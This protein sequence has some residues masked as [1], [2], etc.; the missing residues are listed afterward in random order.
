MSFIHRFAAGLLVAG[1]GAGLATP[2][3]AS[4]LRWTVPET[5]S[6]SDVVDEVVA[7][8]ELSGAAAERVLRA[9]GA[10]AG[11]LLAEQGVLY[12]WDT[13]VP[14]YGESDYD[15]DGDGFADDAAFGT[16]S[17]GG[18]GVD[19][20]GCP[21]APEIVFSPGRAFNNQLNPLAK[22]SEWLS[23]PSLDIAFPPASLGE[24]T[25]VFGFFQDGDADADGIST[26]DRVA[27]GHLHREGIVHR[28]IAARGTVSGVVVRDGRRGLRLAD[29]TVGDGQPVGLVLEGPTPALV[30]PGMTV[31]LDIPPLPVRCGERTPGPGDAAMIKGIAAGARMDAQTA[32]RAYDALLATIVEVVNAGG[33][34]DLGE[35]GLFAAETTITATVT[36]PCAGDPDNCPPPETPLL[37]ADIWE[38]RVSVSGESAAEIDSISRTV[39]ALAERAAER[40]PDAP[41][42]KEVKTEAK[43]K[44]K[45]KAGAELSG[46]VN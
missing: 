10:T 28:D 1:I 16:L 19:S 31:T 44:V 18:T 36:N 9:F 3:M 41:A 29:S 45:F 22:E 26:G 39:K 21:L 32:T 35:V 20:N 25:L 12:L 13:D 8:T 14:A 42:R 7:R 38:M 4:P 5:L 34:A 15:S 11:A 6:A 33:T 17:I 43:R 2:A 23:G 46:Q 30:G 27:V 40:G 24:A 37:S